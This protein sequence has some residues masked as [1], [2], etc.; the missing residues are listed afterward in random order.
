[1]WLSDR[2][3]AR[4]LYPIV[5]VVSVSPTFNHQYLSHTKYHQAS[6]YGLRTPPLCQTVSTHRTGFFRVVFTKERPNF[7][8]RGVRIRKL[9]SRATDNN[10]HI[11]TLLFV[12][13]S[14]VLVVGFIALIVLRVPISFQFH[15]RP[16]IL[17]TVH[18][19]AVS[20]VGT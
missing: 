15:Q 12:F 16:C 6:R 19:V 17:T 3:M 11:T 8:G 7:G 9:M 13:L 2:T 4:P 1:M 20:I 18:V 14:V 10:T 5:Y